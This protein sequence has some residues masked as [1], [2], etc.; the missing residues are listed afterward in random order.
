MELLFKGNKNI[1]LYVNVCV[2]RQIIPT[3]QKFI[4]VIQ[5]KFI[6]ALK[7]T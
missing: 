7:R 4:E 1:K 2:R 5:L 6:H 3:I